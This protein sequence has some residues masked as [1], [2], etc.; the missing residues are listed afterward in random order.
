MITTIV[1]GPQMH[2]S[3]CLSLR[4]S[5][6]L[7]IYLPTNG[8]ARRVWV[9]DLCLLRIWVHGIREASYLSRGIMSSEQSVLF[10][11]LKKLTWLRW[12]VGGTIIYRKPLGI[13]GVLNSNEVHNKIHSERDMLACSVPSIHPRIHP[14]EGWDQICVQRERGWLCGKNKKYI[15]QAE[16]MVSNNCYCI[17]CC[18]EGRSFNQTF[19]VAYFLSST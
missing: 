16:C 3:R 8:E 4:V 5:E 19:N 6:N 15:I 7:R 1:K 11:S 17:V 2:G 9:K 13:I 10:A 12:L 18:T 14:W